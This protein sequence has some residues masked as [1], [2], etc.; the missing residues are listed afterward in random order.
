MVGELV[1]ALK[2]LVNDLSQRKG[3]SGVSELLQLC[4]LERI[5]VRTSGHTFKGCLGLVIAAFEL[6]TDARLAD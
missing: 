6:R 3:I 1:D 5:G 4:E 2:F